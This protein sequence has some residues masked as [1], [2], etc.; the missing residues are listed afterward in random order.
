MALALTKTLTLPE[1]V[2]PFLQGWAGALDSP[3]GRM[4]LAVA[5]SAENVA[6]GTGGPFAALVTEVGTHRIVAAG[7]NV[8][9]PQ[10][11]SLAHGE[12]VALLMAQAALET[13]DLGDSA[14]PALEMATTSQPCIQCYGALIWSGIRKVLVGARGSDVEALVGF[15]EGPVPADWVGQWAIRGIDTEVDVLRDE[16]CAVLRAYKASGAPVYNSASNARAPGGPGGE[17]I[18]G[19]DV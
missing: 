4:R 14:L 5:L 17:G 9:V 10:H 11:T 8:V 13:H 7:V 6:R 12:I 16:A 19:S 2:S 18:H 3:Q 15:D 1:W